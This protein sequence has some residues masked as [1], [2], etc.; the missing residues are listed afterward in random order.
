[1]DRSWLFDKFG[2]IFFIWIMICLSY[3]F[4]Y[5]NNSLEKPMNSNWLRDKF[6]IICFTKM[7]NVCTVHT[8][9]LLLGCLLEP[10]NWNKT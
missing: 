9:K 4:T 3:P 2:I 7:E 10:Y 6:G 5:L 8:V 1:M